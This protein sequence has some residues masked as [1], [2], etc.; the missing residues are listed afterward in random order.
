[1]DHGRTWSL[2][3]AG[4]VPEGTPH[5]LAEPVIP[6]STSH[7]GGPTPSVVG[8]GGVGHVVAIAMRGPYKTSVQ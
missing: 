2:S 8:G 5:D 7:V 4:S 6:L 3:C 1:M